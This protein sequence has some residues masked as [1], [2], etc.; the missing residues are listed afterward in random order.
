MALMRADGELLKFK[1]KLSNYYL[2]VLEDFGVTP[3]TQQR[4]SDLLEIMDDRVGAKSTIFI[5][6]RPYNDSHSFIDDPILV[7]AVLDRL[8]S[9][10]LHIKLKGQSREKRRQTLMT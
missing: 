8:S 3:M 7:D 6:Q 10:R 9:N 5:G 2:L 4:K 1:A